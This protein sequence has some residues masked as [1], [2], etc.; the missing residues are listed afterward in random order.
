[1]FHFVRARVIRRTRTETL[2]PVADVL[3]HDFPQSFAFPF[4]PQGFAVTDAPEA[5]HGQYTIMGLIKRIGFRKRCQRDLPQVSSFP[6]LYLRPIVSDELVL[7]S[8]VTL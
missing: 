2:P 7:L 5:V 8:C 4:L 1:M 6:G 3:A